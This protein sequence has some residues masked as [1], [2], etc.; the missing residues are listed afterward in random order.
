M[1]WLALTSAI[2]VGI[3]A[4][5]EAKLLIAWLRKH[6][7]RRRAEKSWGGPVPKPWEIRAEGVNQPSGGSH[8]H[9]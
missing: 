5:D 9:R 6:F 8:V 4:A 2:A 1:T 3:V 7:A